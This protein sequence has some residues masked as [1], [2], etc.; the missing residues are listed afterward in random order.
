MYVDD[1]D[2]VD[3]ALT[4]AVR[5]C[6]PYETI[7]SIIEQTKDINYK[8]V[9][10]ETAFSLMCFKYIYDYTPGPFKVSRLS[11]YTKTIYALLD[12]GADPYLD[13]SWTESELLDGLKA[14]GVDIHDYQSRQEEL[15]K[16]VALHYETIQAVKHKNENNEF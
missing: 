4:K 2:N 13:D 9:L 16:M 14:T 1:S 5:D 10:G 8:T 6:R 7:K 11:D 3:N 15:K 12:A